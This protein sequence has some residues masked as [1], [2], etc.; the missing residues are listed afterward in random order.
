MQTSNS[1]QLHVRK[2]LPWSV[3]FLL[4]TTLPYVMAVLNTPPD[5][6]FLG[7]LVNSEDFSTFISAMRQGQ[8]GQWLFQ[9]TFSAEPWQPQ[10]MHFTYILLGKVASLVGGDLVIW[11]HIYRFAT[12][13]F[14]LWMLLLW[15]RTLWP[16][17]PQL[18]FTAWFLC[19]F[20]SGIG[21]LVAIAGLPAPTTDLTG[22]E[23]TVFMALFHT[24]HYALGL[25][26]EILLF[27]SV[28]K[29]IRDG[30]GW[31]WTAVGT[32]AS[33][34]SSLTYVYHIPITGL[35]IA[36]YIFFRAVRN[37]TISWRQLTHIGIVLLPST[38][39]LAYYG[40]FANRDPY[41]REYAQVTHTVAPPSLPGVAI[42][43][44]L[45]GIFALFGAGSWFKNKQ[46]WLVPIWAVVNISM[47]YIP[48]TNFMGRFVLGL[49]V[50]IATM[51]AYGLEN[52]ILPDLQKRPFFTR[53]AR[54]T[55]TPYDSLRRIFLALAMPTTLII[56]FW[57]A[58]SATLATD[59]P[60]YV[61]AAEVAALNWL[62]QNTNHEDLILIDYPMGN[63]LP[64]VAA[65]KSFTGHF[66]F[67]TNLLQKNRIVEQFWQPE[68]SPEWRQ[69][70]IETWGI[71]YIY[72]G[73]YERSLYGQ[74]VDLPGDVV[75]EQGGVTIYRLS[76]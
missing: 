44:G 2:I 46:T 51:A 32:L 22:P 21:W 68:T 20:G 65:A 58:R 76:E 37:R 57:L 9:F 70:L 28:I 63:F 26:L 52:V 31:L 8:T 56:P 53:F 19:G 35:V 1:S 18:Q 69:A 39:L 40:G 41:F 48:F 75:Y 23:W 73:A 12:A 54:V 27:C 13:V 14:A 11:F 64:R 15:V 43:L 62:G 38:I 6:V 59:F 34:A 17:Q 24:P 74:P 33:L 10:L 42:G 49:I 45:L 72:Q 16:G 50:P 67:T 60:T 7:A 66:H 3:L 36:F 30:A 71:D 5:K 47:L 25:A 4:L 55:P 61:S 29:L